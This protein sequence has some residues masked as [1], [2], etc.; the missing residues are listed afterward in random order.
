MHVGILEVTQLLVAVV[1][2]GFAVATVMLLGGRLNG[3]P[4][5]GSQGSEP[6][7]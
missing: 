3:P 5:Q 7:R 2:G 4:P 1:V 6:Q